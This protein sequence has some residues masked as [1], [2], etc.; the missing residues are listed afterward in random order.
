MERGGIHKSQ[1]LMQFVPQ[2]GRQTGAWVKEADQAIADYTD[3]LRVD[4]LC[5][6]A[7][8]ERAGMWTLKG[9]FDKAV[10][11]LSEA[12]TFRRQDG[13]LYFQ[14]GGV[15]QAAGDLDAAI[16]DFTA[17]IRLDPR[18][19]AH[20][21]QQRGEA[22]AAKR[23]YSRAI[24]DF[25]EAIRQDPEDTISRDKRRDVWNL[26]G[27]FDKSLEDL[28][29]LVR[30][31]PDDKWAHYDL[32]MLLASCPD[33]ALRDGRKAVEHARKACEL[34]EWKDAMI[35]GALAAAE[36]ETGDFKEAVNFQKKSLGL[37]KTDEQK[38][39]YRRRLAQYER[40]EPYREAPGEA[41]NK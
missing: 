10:A 25:D 11:D 35:V 21:Y 9:E 12:I 39:E 26:I 8:H 31:H 33:A 20:Y 24:D 23:H 30:K 34:S 29:E 2:A 38:A 7:Y 19:P 27:R 32:A 36:A 41:G 37:L 13:R 18:D 40:G 16:E 14:R 17:A 1:V 15:H 3:A 4:R 28:Q 6:D 22:W 5:V